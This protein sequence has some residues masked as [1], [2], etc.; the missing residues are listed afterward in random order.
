[1]KEQLTEFKSLLEEVRKQLLDAQMHF[2]IWEQLWPTEKK[3]DVI[4][5][6]IGFFQPTRAAHLDRFFIKISNVVDNHRNSPSIYRLLN[7]V[8]SYMDLAPG[9]DMHSI[10]DRLK[11]QKDL[12]RRI[13]QYRNKRAAHWDMA[14]KP[15]PVFVGESRQLLME[16]ASIFNEIHGAHD[17]NVWSFRPQQYHDTDRLLD[18]LRKRNQR[19]L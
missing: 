1:M 5:S 12:L 8:G 11:K 15:D 3:V 2:D 7:M 14:A 4:N 13:R 10:H 16:L 18:R 19:N 17:K 6:Y 9:I